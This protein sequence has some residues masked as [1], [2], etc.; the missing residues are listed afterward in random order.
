MTQNNEMPS[1]TPAPETEQ[2]AKTAKTPSPLRTY[3][4]LLL[5][6][7]LCLNGGLFA[8]AHMTYKNAYDRE[9][10]AL[11]EDGQALILMTGGYLASPENGS[12]SNDTTSAVLSF[13]AAK[14]LALTNGTSWGSQLTLEG[15]D[16][17]PPVYDSGSQVT[18]QTVNGQ[19]Y[20]CYSF[21]VSL[22]LTGEIIYGSL[23]FLPQS[24]STYYLLR[25]IHSLEKQHQTTTLVTAL[26][27]LVLSVLYAVVSWVALRKHSLAVCEAAVVPSENDETVAA[28]LPPIPR[29]QAHNAPQNDLGLLCRHI[30]E[31]FADEADERGVELRGSAQMKCFVKCDTKGL[32][33]LT[34][35]LLRL[36]LTT[37]AEGD[38]LTLLVTK[39]GEAVALKLTADT[40]T[41]PENALADC[42]QTALALGGELTAEGGT[43]AVTWEPRT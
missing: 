37:L 41:L 18:R 15:Q 23:S 40:A 14:T 19:T 34:E 28:P 20:L 33:L 4:V 13:L 1:Q 32:N 27:S 25:N 11:M 42:R 12:I 7:C 36:Y 39:N 9:V 22:Q 43:V 35:R 26:A 30:L 16:W 6:F 3:I 38:C 24:S 17:T 29:R 2:T 8:L 5:L 10:Q 21:R 31:R